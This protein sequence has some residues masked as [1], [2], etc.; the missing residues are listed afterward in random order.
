MILIKQVAIILGFW[1]LGELIAY[2]TALPIP[3]SIAAMLLI[4]TALELK[5]IH[6][7]DI[8]HVADFL[9]NNMALFFI[10]AGVG[11]MSHFHI[12]KQE[13]LPISIAIIVS[14]LLVLTVVGLIMER[15]K[16]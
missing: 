15:G 5:I 6:S 2:F 7:R 11:L 4:V 1:L 12:L 10:P 3:G 8:N 9:L 16:K 13:W 14:T